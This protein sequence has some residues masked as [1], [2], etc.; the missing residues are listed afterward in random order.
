[1]LQLELKPHGGAA[2]EALAR[3]GDPGRFKFALPMR[4]Y[5]NCDFSYAGLKTSVRLA[6]EAELPEPCSQVRARRQ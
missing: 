1:M 3:G 2:L 5:A 6:I 4:K